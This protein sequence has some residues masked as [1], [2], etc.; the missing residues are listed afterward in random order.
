[1]QP[2]LIVNIV[3][4]TPRLLGPLT[5]QLA[6]FAQGGTVRSMTSAAPGLT[7]PVQASML[8][9][10]APDGHG[11][12][13]NGWY[14]RDLAEIG[15]WKQSNQLVG[16]EKLWE[17]AKRRDPAFTCANLFWWCNMASHHDIGVTPRPIYT[18]DGRKLTNCYTK[19]PSLRDTLTARLGAFPLFQFWGPGTTIASTEW[20]ARATMIA[21]DDADP[22]LTLAYLPHLDYDLQRYGP[23]DT[24]PAVRQSLADI[25][26][27]AGTLI[28]QAQATGRRV[29][30]VSEYGVVP[31]D[32]VVYLNQELRA[33]GLLAVRMEDG[34]ELLDPIASAA[35]AVVDHQLA[36]I[37]VADAGR[38]EAVRALIA[39]VPGVESVW[40]G[41][42]RAAAGFDHARAGD[43]VVVADARSWFSYY[44][45]F[46]DGR[47]PDF[48]RTV[49]IHRKPGY[50]PAELFFDPALRF[51]R[52]AVL[53]RLARRKLGLRFLMDVIGLDAAIVKGSH[54]R[55]VDDPALGPLVISD[56]PAAFPPGPV[57]ACAI[58]Q[59]ALDIVFGS[60]GNGA[61]GA[62]A[63]QREPVVQAH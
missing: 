48:A 57:D 22:T 54:G 38:V 24:H 12:V 1:M 6:A 16:G 23:D 42:E 40:C 10:L 49:E 41:A 52:L 20:I 27:V 28:A 46:D 47:A 8:T 60:A 39:S 31:V 45:W 25:D 43:L 51:P 26:R 11:I 15:F 37:Y 62:V 36:H 14:M 21:I 53:V 9:G 2:L 34:A 17:T 30:V 61:I 63:P 3:G 32:R 19:P 44:Y 5:P 56:H 33:A 29:L 13:A 55:P 7:C 50:D 58:K 59:I 4:L 18:A 35:F